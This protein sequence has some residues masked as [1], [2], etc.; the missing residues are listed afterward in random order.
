MKQLLLAMTLC[1]MPFF[2]VAVAGDLT[3]D[4][5]AM[6]MHLQAETQAIVPGQQQGLT[7]DGASRSGGAV[8]L[9]NTHTKQ[10]IVGGAVGSESAENHRISNAIEL[11]ILLEF[12][13]PKLAQAAISQLS[14]LC[15]A[16]RLSFDI[17]HPF[18]IIGHTDAV[19]NQAYNLK[20][21]V[22]RAEAVSLYLVDE[23]GIASGRL[24]ADGKGESEL[25][26]GL[27]PR[28]PLHRR[29]E[30]KIRK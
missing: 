11:Q 17:Q 27:N 5:I 29:V 18:A 6:R 10:E 23:C 1:A 25:R 12:S 16:F 8:G 19:G 24:T 13:S 22:E 9:G 26:A 4:E 14:E 30:V 3:A 20:L 7:A 21:S 2:A 28:D 15:K